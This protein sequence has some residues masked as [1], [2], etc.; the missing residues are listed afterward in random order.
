MLSSCLMTTGPLALGG[1]VSCA[2]TP[3]WLTTA[4]TSAAAP[5]IERSMVPDQNLSK[6]LCGPAAD[7]QRECYRERVYVLAALPLAAELKWPGCRGCD[8]CTC[9]LRQL[10]C[11]RSPLLVALFTG[12]PVYVT[13]RCEDGRQTMSSLSAMGS[14]AKSTRRWTGPQTS[15]DDQACSSQLPEPRSKFT[16]TIM[17]EVERETH[18]EDC[19]S[20]AIKEA[21]K[22]AGW[23]LATSGILVSVAN[24]ISPAFQRALGVSGKAAL[25][26]SPTLTLR[27]RHS[28]AWHN[29][30]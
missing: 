29:L 3:H 7:P 5:T 6:M 14:A 20:L 13:E 12:A 11:R 2:A 21:S 22:S 18:K 23:A 24:G 15:R 28:R 8:G 26:V 9:P 30:Q 16:R 19:T 4:S 17:A 10:L 25:V 1:S 27:P